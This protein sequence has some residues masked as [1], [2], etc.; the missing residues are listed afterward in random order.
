MSTALKFKYNEHYVMSRNSS[1]DLVRIPK[2]DANYRYCIYRNFLKKKYIIIWVCPF[3]AVIEKQKL[4]NQAI[5]RSRH[6]INHGIN[7]HAG[8]NRGKHNDISDVQLMV[9]EFSPLQK[10]KHCR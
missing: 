3:I 7:V 9:I 1:G 2:G 6:L 4:I 5:N 10:I 8:A